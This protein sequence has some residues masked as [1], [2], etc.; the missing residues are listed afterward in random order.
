MIS[1]KTVAI[2]ALNTEPKYFT[3][4]ELFD[5]STN[6]RLVVNEIFQA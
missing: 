3:S 4:G 6:I 1:L 5:P 2:I